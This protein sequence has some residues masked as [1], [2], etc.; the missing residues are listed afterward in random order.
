MNKLTAILVVWGLLASV[1]AVYNIQER[2]ELEIQV[3]ELEFKL[4]GYESSSKNIKEKNQELWKEIERLEEENRN[5][6]LKVQTLELEKKELEQKVEELEGKISVL[7]HIINELKKVPEGYYETDFFP[8]HNNTAEELKNFLK[9]EFEL[10]HKYE[11]G[12]FDC[13]EIASYTEWALEDA[14]F[15][16]YIAEGI[17]EGKEGKIGHAWVIVR[18]G[19]QEFYVDPSVMRK[20]DDRTILIPPGGYKV[21]PSR[22]YGNIYEAIEDDVSIR[23]WDWWDVVGFPPETLNLGG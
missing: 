10:P 13:S 11:E 3:K 4:K 20:D 21:K 7:N 18:V 12:V 9:Y 19:G 15:D 23:E 8:D 1:I 17:Y 2:Q 5:L 14:G 16:A 22:V 6:S